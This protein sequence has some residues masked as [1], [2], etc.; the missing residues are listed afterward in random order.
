M[1]QR[2]T[3]SEIRELLR[4]QPGQEPVTIV[5]TTLHAV[6][7]TLRSLQAGV[8]PVDHSI[9]KIAAAMGYLL[10]GCEAQAA[11]SA[12]QALVGIALPAAMPRAGADQLLEGLARLREVLAESRSRRSPSG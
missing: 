8:F 2:L 1:S 12:H 11:R 10:A 7:A 5:A 4:P 3:R 6:D 9:H